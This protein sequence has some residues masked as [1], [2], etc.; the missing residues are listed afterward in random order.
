MPIMFFLPV[1]YQD[2]RGNIK[3]PYSDIPITL[4]EVAGRYP[5]SV[6]YLGRCDDAAK[7]AFGSTIRYVDLLRNEPFLMDNAQ[8]TAQA[9]VAVYAQHM[10]TA[11]CDTRCV[12]IGYGRIA[13]HLCALL[14]VFGADV[15]ATARKEKDLAAIR[16]EL[17]DAVHTGDVHRVLA[18]A[19]VIWNTVP[20]RVLGE[21]ELA[22]IRG[23]A[24][25]ELASPPYGMDMAQA[26]KMGVGVRIE[27]G[28][29]GRVFPNSAARGDIVRL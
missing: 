6:Y 26:K 29:P 3:T 7:A 27:S 1:P 22:C 8:L 11:L 10:D 12:V 17:M 15:T 18:D 16:A 2:G 5:R 20:A 23:A 13:K 14:R 9:A 25:I 4:Q 19:D 28:L 21:R 24:V